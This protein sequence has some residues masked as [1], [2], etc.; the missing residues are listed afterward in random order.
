MT[1]QETGKILTVIMATYPTNFSGM[2]EKDQLVLLS[3]WETMLKGYSYE[4]V[5]A[6]LQAFLLNDTKGFPPSPGQLIAQISKRQT[7]DMTAMEAWGLV[8]KAI[9]RAG[10]YAQEEFDKLPEICQRAIGSP[11]NLR[12]MARMDAKTVNSVEQAQFIKVYDDL[13]KKQAEDRVVP[14]AVLETLRKAAPQLGG[15]GEEKKLPGKEKDEQAISEKA[16]S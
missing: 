4:V 5:G 2:S 3:T 9:S 7:A 12:D 15:S 16:E 14:E 11:D 10:Y 8:S 1:R 6:A 13:A